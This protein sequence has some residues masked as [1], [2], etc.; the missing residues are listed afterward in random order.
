MRSAQAAFRASLVALAAAIAALLAH[1]T[2]D[3]AGDFL[4]AHD[5]YDGIDH[6][7]R[8]VFV[9]AIAALAI[10]V[11]ARVLFDVLDRRCGSTKSLLRVVRTK[12]GSPAPFVLQTAGL[13]I[14]T[15]AGM[16]LL[17][18]VTTATPV[19]DVADLFGGSLALGLSA[20]IASGAAIGWIVHRLVRLIADH[21]PAIAVLVFRLVRATP[22]VSVEATAIIRAHAPRAIV[23]SLLLA[24]RGSKRGPPLLI[25]A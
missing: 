20:T 1:V 2:I 8:A 5:T 16:E 3:I 23:R 12:L 11:T 22:G 15:L 9:V 17:D 21:E 24:R 13:A 14:L 4:L 10:A 18:C 7:S 6:E 19:D 25:P